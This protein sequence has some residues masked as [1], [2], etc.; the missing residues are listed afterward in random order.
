MVVWF[1]SCESMLW[2]HNRRSFLTTPPQKR[3]I[4][5]RKRHFDL[6]PW[7]TEKQSKTIRNRHTFL[8]AS[9][10]LF[11]AITEDPLRSLI[12]ANASLINT[13][14]AIVDL[15]TLMENIDFHVLFYRAFLF[16]CLLRSLLSCVFIFFSF[17]AVACSLIF[18]CV[19]TVLYYFSRRFVPRGYVDSTRQRRATFDC[20]TWIQFMTFNILLSIWQM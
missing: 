5:A 2:F 20:S 4:F 15:D 13:K 17:R 7:Y 12:S 10:H 3:E 19:V 18:G 8:F 14:V 11:N 16:L 6:G 9:I 1:D